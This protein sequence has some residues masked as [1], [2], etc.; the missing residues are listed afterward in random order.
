MTNALFPLA[1]KFQINYE[2]TSEGRIYYTEDSSVATYRVFILLCNKK[3]LILTS[4]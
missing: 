4:K 3:R 1:L 2:I